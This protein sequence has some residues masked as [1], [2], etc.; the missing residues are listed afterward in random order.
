MRGHGA[1]RALPA[2]GRSALAGLAALLLLGA[3]Q[4]RDVTVGPDGE[5]QSLAP[6][7]LASAPGDRLLVEPGTYQA[8]DVAVPHE[9]TVEGQGGVTI[10]SDEFVAK[11]LFVPQGDF[12]VRN[13]TLAGARAPDLNG[14]GIRHE[15][16]ALLVEDVTFR[17]NEDG[18]LATGSPE[19]SVTVRRSLF[20]GNGH[21]DGYSHALYQFAGASL[22]VEDSRFVGT[23]AGHHV[24]SLAP[25]VVVTRSSFD[26]ADADTSYV[27]DATGGGRLVVTRNEVVR[28]A[29]ADQATLIN[30]DTSRGG[31]PG[32][33]TVEDNVVTTAKRR[34]RALRNPEGAPVSMTG[35]AWRRA[36]RGSYAGPLEADDAA[37]APTPEQPAPDVA[38]AAPDPAPDPA[39]GPAPGPAPLSAAD[40]A[41]LTPQQRRAVRRVAEA[42]DR[43][44]AASEGAAPRPTG[45]LR[46]PRV[47]APEGAYAAYRLVPGG[48]GS[49][50]WTT[51]GAAFAP[52][53]LPRGADAQAFAGDAPLPTQ[54]DVLATH[55]DGSAR[56]AAVTIAHGLRPGSEQAVVLRPRRTPEGAAQGRGETRPPLTV[57]V[58]GTGPDGAFDEAVTLGTDEEAGTWLSGPLLTERT[59]SYRLTPLL[60]LRADVRA[61]AAGPERV[62]LTLENHEAYL[63]GPRD[64]AYAVTAMRGD[65]AVWRSPQVRHHR[66]AGWTVV[67]PGA[68]ASHVVQHDPEALIASGA[69]LPFD[70]SVPVRAEAVPEVFGG[71][72]LPGQHAF[73]TPYMP[74]TG[75][76]AE[77]GPVTAWTAAWLKSQH[78]GALAA[79]IRAAEVGITVPWHFEED[80]AVVT[81]AR[82]AGFWAD[83]RGAD[84][85]PDGFPPEAWSEA[86][87]GWTPDLAHKPDLAF[88]AYLA[89]AEPAFARALAHEAAYAVTGA[90]PQLRG[91]G[92]D[93]LLDLYQTR[94]TA[95]SLRTIGNAAWALPDDDPL[96]AELA[97][98]LA[99]NLAALPEH[100]YAVGPAAGVLPR[101]ADETTVAPWQQD[102]LVMTLAQEALRGSQD[103]ASAVRRVTPYLSGR[104]LDAGAGVGFAAASDHVVARGRVPARSWAEIVGASPPGEPYLGSADGY[105]AVLLAA[106]SAAHAATG[107]AR[108]A[109]AAQRLVREPGAEGLAAPDA[110][111]G[112]AT[113]PQ[114]GLALPEGVKRP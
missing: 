21:G 12:T 57:R 29:G 101:Y 26:D 40:I 83:A 114:M 19:G 34:T 89:T 13:V 27:V 64:L 70:L 96:K 104:V 93:I 24:K 80:G 65:E 91:P 99:R 14:A 53:V 105:H 84:G 76:R 85:G 48:P 98:A 2:G 22:L 44:P 67:L 11:G 95:W 68:R 35:N 77:I 63:P 33:V 112:L 108:L 50:P 66:H 81:P 74:Q 109:L 94:E 61:Y 55:P 8:S 10:T 38:A 100:T 111:Y 58:T 41:K 75:G 82:R 79:V 36:G 39:P 3:A 54:V 4:A 88:P 37:R 5:Y 73:L 6:A 102:F 42:L 69:F 78:P 113:S 52:G 71:P 46:P 60:R 49:L 86:P 32:S 47:E 18:I 72:V 103:A 31:T 59:E 107:E 9:L 92:G 110:R 30:Y 16:G 25:L 62:R 15:G 45:L 56:H 51:F 97:R 106:L 87:G 28:R 90:W 43:A 7:V 20:E 23:R 17:G 1:P